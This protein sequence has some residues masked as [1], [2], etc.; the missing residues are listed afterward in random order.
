MS[1]AF[2]ITDPNYCIVKYRSPIYKNK[3][4]EKSNKYLNQNLILLRS[5]YRGN[6]PLSNQ[7]NFKDIYSYPVK[8]KR[9]NSN[10]SKI[11]NPYH[12]FYQTLF[13]KRFPSK[14]SKLNKSMEGTLN[15]GIDKKINEAKTIPKFSIHAEK[16]D[17]NPIK[18]MITNQ[19]NYIKLN[20]FLNQNYQV[21]KRKFSKSFYGSFSESLDSWKERINHDSNITKSSV[22]YNILANNYLGVA[23]LNFDSILDKKKYFKM[24]SIGE[25]SDFS[26]ICGIRKNN[27][28]LMAVNQD[29]KIFYR[30]NGIFTNYMDKSS[31][32]EQ[33]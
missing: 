3:I 31:K 2:R 5:N 24:K 22:K 30:C 1:K 23:N 9:N 20:E 8:D 10:T 28:Y 33:I 26:Q 25:Y 19:K 13:S 18:G 12:E 17:E 29:P 21:K 27:D 32:I 6:I 15:L 7:K 11:M 4:S 14:Q 16:N